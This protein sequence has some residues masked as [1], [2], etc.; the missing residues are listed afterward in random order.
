MLNLE[1]GCHRIDQGRGTIG[2]AITVDD[3]SVEADKAMMNDPLRNI[4]DLVFYD[5][6]DSRAHLGSPNFDFI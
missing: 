3:D 1:L 4:I 5:H 6:A 2:G